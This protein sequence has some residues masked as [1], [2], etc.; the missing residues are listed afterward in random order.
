MAARKTARDGLPAAV[1]EHYGADCPVPPAVWRHFGDADDEVSLILELR[2]RASAPTVARQLRQ[3]WLTPS[4]EPRIKSVSS[5]LVVSVTISDAVVGLLPYTTW[6][7]LMSQAAQLSAADI[8]D[9]L[10]DLRGGRKLRSRPGWQARES[11]QLRW[12]L[13][14]L[15]RALG[16]RTSAARIV[17]L[18]QRAVE[19]VGRGSDPP[20]RTVGVNRDV[21][22]ALFE[23]RVT[24]KADAAER[25]FDI[26]A[27]GITW[28]VIDSG[29]D[30]GNPAFDD[31]KEGSRV[32]RS[33]DVAGAVERLL[34]DEPSW[35]L[36]LQTDAMWGKFAE[37][38]PRSRRRPSPTPRPV[39][40][41]RTSPGSSPPTNG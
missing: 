39:I 34:Q 3:A 29:I 14:Q 22:P 26:D 11:G 2:D 19:N 17:E 6:Q 40:T 20:I 30:A 28:A 15:T 27:S 41:G 38:A 4:R 25:V 36:G 31:G 37:L 1:L 33:F 35:F 8:R 10:E 16:Q 5:F 32:L 21:R 23:S 18:F 12:L 24:V 9:E 13:S 7:R